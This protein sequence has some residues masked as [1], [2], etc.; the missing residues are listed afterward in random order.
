[1]DAFQLTLIFFFFGAGAGRC[2]AGEQNIDEDSQTYS[3]KY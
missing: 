2:Y 3:E 1:M